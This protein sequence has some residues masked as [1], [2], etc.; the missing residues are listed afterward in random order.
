[1]NNNV[2]LQISKAWFTMGISIRLLFFTFDS[3]DQMINQSK[4]EKSNRKINY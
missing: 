1:M 3:N 4:C 2:P